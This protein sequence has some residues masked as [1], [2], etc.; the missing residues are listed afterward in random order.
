MEEYTSNNANRFLHAA[1]VPLAIAEVSPFT[2]AQAAGTGSLAAPAMAAPTTGMLTE[3]DGPAAG[4]RAHVGLSLDPLAM[5]VVRAELEEQARRS[6][7]TS[8]AEGTS[9]VCAVYAHGG[10][11]PDEQFS[12][13]HLVRLM[14]NVR[15][16]VPHHSPGVGVGEGHTS[17]MEEFPVAR[18]GY[19]AGFTDP[20]QYAA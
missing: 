8:D 6:D 12:P 9:S 19:I 2:P 10:D 11:A 15:T 14:R 13:P 5:T 7:E 17:S 16:R 4:T 20:Q 3:T 1:A 18:M